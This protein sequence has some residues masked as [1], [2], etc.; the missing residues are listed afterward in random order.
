MDISKLAI[1]ASE[2]TIALAYGIIDSYGVEIR[3]IYSELMKK[4]SEVYFPHVG[5][6]MGISSHNALPNLFPFS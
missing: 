3:A 6:E 4:F 2:I 5:D 1:F